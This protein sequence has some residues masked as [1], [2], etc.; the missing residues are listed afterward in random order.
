M[1]GLGDVVGAAVLFHVRF[2]HR[3]EGVVGGQ[4]VGVELVLPQLGR[5]RLLEDAG[6]NHFAAAVAPPREAVHP[7]LQHVLQHR[8]AARHVAVE[9]GVAHAHLALVPGRQHEPSELV[10]EGHQQ[11][12]ADARLQVLFRHVRGG[13]RERG[14][15]GPVVGARE[16]GD[17]H[18]EQLDPQAGRQLPGVLPVRGGGEPGGHRDRGH[19]VGAEGVGGHGEGEGRVDAPGQAQHAVPEPVL[20]EIVGGAQGQR[21]VDLGLGLQQRRDPGRRLR[22]PRPR[23]RPDGD[24]THAVAVGAGLP[25][26]RVVEAPPGGGDGVEVDHQEVFFELRAAGE[27]P[28]AG[29]DDEAVAVEDQLVLA[30]DGVAEGH[31][32]AVV[33]RPLRQHPFP[34]D[35]LPPVIR[36]AGEV[37]QNHRAAVD[38]R[39]PARSPRVPEVLADGDAGAD[40][41]EVEGQRRVAPGEVPL[42]VEDRVVRQEVFPVDAGDLAAG[43]D[44]GGVVQVAGQ[45]RQ[46]DHRDRAGDRRRE[47]TDPV[48]RGFG[49]PRVQ[50][51]VFGRVPGDRQFR[52][53]GQVRAAGRGAGDQAADAVEVAVEV[54]DG[55]VALAQGHPQGGA[56]RGPV[57]LGRHGAASRYHPVEPKPPSDRAVSERASASTTSTST[58]GVTTSC[59]TFMPRRTRKVRRPWLTRR[60][61]TSPR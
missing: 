10:G 37:D 24:R 34:L 53:D 29:V 44:R 11:V 1:S 52:E 18:L 51:Q 4:A 30:P 25:P 16:V 36:R 35:A 7:A 19:R 23:R 20:A 6:R 43:E 2:E 42:L 56:G 31:E 54:A 22:P 14:G 47:T 33:G 32:A 13:V 49:E 57:R 27:D 48:R 3:V 58:T 60:M 9:G 21:A 28:P 45:G 46:P 50:E 61:P 15:E 41:P 8:E 17:R 40:A 39:P 59:A 38:R 26:P 5:R 12:A 55:Q